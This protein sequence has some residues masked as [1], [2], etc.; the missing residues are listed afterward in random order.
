MHIEYH[1][2]LLIQPN[3]TIWCCFV[4]P[5]LIQTYILI[6]M[7]REHQDLMNSLD[8]MIKAGGDIS[9]KQTNGCA[10]CNRAKKEDSYC[11]S[12]HETTIDSHIIV[13]ST[14]LVFSM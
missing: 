10:N 7:S 14:K 4:Q 6:N 3:T 8:N 1:S 9:I 12:C 11:R 2:S 13:V 5:D